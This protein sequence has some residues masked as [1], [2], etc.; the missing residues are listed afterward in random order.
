MNVLSQ[1]RAVA[2]FRRLTISEALSVAERQATLLLKLQGIHGPPVPSSAI[3]ELSFLTVA[4]RS[5]MASL[6]ATKWIK[7]RWVVLINGLE[8][9]VRQRF[10]LGHELKHII[11]HAHAARMYGPCN[12]RTEGRIE[13]LCDFFSGCVLM[14]RPWVKGAY[15]SGIQNVGDLAQ[16]FQVSSRAVQVRLLQLGIVDASARCGGMDNEFLR[17]LPASPLG[18]A[19]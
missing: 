4:V 13:K 8:P 18:L 9:V 3:S 19:A 6:A 2:P 7:P 14:P 1:L 12:A 5:P 11:D 17:S 15:A 10:S 16:L